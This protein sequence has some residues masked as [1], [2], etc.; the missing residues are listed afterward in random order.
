MNL[1]QMLPLLLL[2]GAVGAMMYFGT[3]KQKR[4]AAAT[5]AMQEAIV[6]GTRVMTTSGMHAT[7]TAV[8]ADTIELEIAPDVYTTW[9]RAA[10]REIVVAGPIEEDDYVEEDESTIPDGSH[11]NLEDTYREDSYESE[12]P[13][14]LEKRSKDIS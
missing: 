6:P 8:A 4:L 12:H 10:V 14:L 7:V 9:V 5:A 3:R 2:F 13:V 1:Q 11:D